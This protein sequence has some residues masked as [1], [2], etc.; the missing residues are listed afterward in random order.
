M[1]TPV[2]EIPSFSTNS[3]MALMRLEISSENSF[4]A[5]NIR[6]DNSLQLFILSKRFGWICGSVLLYVKLPWNFPLR[7][8]SSAWPML[9]IPRLNLP[10]APLPSLASHQ[11]SLTNFLLIYTPGWRGSLWEKVFCKRTKHI[12]PAMLR[13]Q[14]SWPWF[15]LTNHKATLSLQEGRVYAESFLIRNKSHKTKIKFSYLI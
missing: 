5:A 11:A 15:H 2:D 1:Q 12:G 13:M 9:S 14:T 8:E 7:L 3:L 10:P 6:G 4:Y